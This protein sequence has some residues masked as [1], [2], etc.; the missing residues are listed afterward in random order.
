MYWLIKE[1]GLWIFPSELRSRAQGFLSMYFQK[2]QTW[3]NSDLNIGCCRADYINTAIKNNK[4][5]TAC[6]SSGPVAPHQLLLAIHY[7]KPMVLQGSC[8]AYLAVRGRNWKL[9]YLGSFLSTA[10]NFVTVNNVLSGVNTA[11][12]ISCRLCHG[13]DAL[14]EGTDS[15]TAP[16]SN[17]WCFTES[18][19]S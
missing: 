10:V 4:K 3:H 6:L 14:T 2:Q 15:L 16:L 12:I 7:L 13:F 19:M 5:A 9:D 11:V 18:I 17:L 8:P 1:S